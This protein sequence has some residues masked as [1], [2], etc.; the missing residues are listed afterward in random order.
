MKKHD[1]L[2]KGNY[3][4]IHNHGNSDEHIFKRE[5]NYYFFLKRQEKYMSKHWELI[6]WHLLPDS[7]QLLVKIKSDLPEDISWEEINKKIYSDFGHF[8]NGYAKAINKAFNRR[9]SLFAKSFSRKLLAG[10]VEIKQHI[11]SIHSKPLKRGYATSIADWKF[12]SYRKALLYSKT[13]QYQEMIRLFENA[14]NFF[15]EHKLFEMQ[16]IAA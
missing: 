1:F 11:C 7:Y 10:N 8:T 16:N 12:S 3:Y 6:A 9:G 13:P 4:L 5:E 14:E 15:A 2:V